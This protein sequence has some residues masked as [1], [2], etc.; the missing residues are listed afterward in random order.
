M[1]SRK[2]RLIEALEAEL[3][4]ARFVVADRELALDILRRQGSGPM[5]RAFRHEAD[6]RGIK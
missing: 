5:T 4:E 6:A 1:K 2:R 3:K